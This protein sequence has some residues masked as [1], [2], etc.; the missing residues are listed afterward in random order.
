[1]KRSE[2]CGLMMMMLVA[3]RTQDEGATVLFIVWM[4]LMV[5][6]LLKE[7]SNEGL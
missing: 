6:A 5:V 2:Y 7:I 1:M 3:P 4:V